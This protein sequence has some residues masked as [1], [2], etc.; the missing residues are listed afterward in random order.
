[1]LILSDSRQPYRIH[2]IRS[3]S[4][5]QGFSINV[6]SMRDIHAPTILCN[7][8]ACSD[9]CNTKLMNTTWNIVYDIFSLLK[10]GFLLAICHKQY[11]CWHLG[12]QIGF[13]TSLSWTITHSE[14]QHTFLASLCL[15][16]APTYLASNI[17]QWKFLWNFFNCSLRTQPFLDWLRASLK[18]LGIESDG[19][20]VLLDYP[21]SC[22]AGVVLEE[23]LHFLS[24]LLSHK[25]C[26][27]NL[28]GGNLLS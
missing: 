23:L 10:V 12:C 7:V 27:G 15:V 6:T 20:T 8:H 25:P 17:Q 9:Q 3:L 18:Q 4:R 21:V 11:F 2:N 26:R 1:M 24:L 28:G 19:L 5:G 14:Q 16:S 13:W 22:G